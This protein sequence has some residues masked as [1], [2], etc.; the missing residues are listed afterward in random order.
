M[1]MEVHRLQPEITEAAT[2]HGALTRQIAELGKTIEAR[3]DVPDDVKASFDA[4]RKELAGLAPRLTLPQG[5]GGGGAGRGG[6]PESLVARVG[7]AKNGLMA[8]M[9]PAD[10]TIRA[11]TEVKAQTPKAIADMN[12]A[13]AKATILSS[14]LAKYN[15]TLTVPAPIVIR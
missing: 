1:A 11:Y 15:L 8:G 12:A 10:P 2:A 7:Q 5:R 6:A 14:A 4:F 9:S 13:I 3:S